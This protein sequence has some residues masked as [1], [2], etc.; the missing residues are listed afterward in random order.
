MAIVFVSACG[1]IAM[2][3]ERGRAPSR[4]VMGINLID[5]DAPAA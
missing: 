5:I 3:I 1:H 2:P 4:I